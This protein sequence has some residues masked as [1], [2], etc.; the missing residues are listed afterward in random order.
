MSRDD[1]L[2]ALGRLVV[3][4]RTL[5][6]LREARERAEA[7]GH[8]EFGGPEIDRRTLEFR[9]IAKE[10][11]GSLRELDGS[12]ARRL[13]AKESAVREVVE[14]SRSTSGSPAPA[15]WM[16]VVLDYHRLLRESLAIK[17]WLA[18]RVPR[19]E[20]VGAATVEEYLEDRRARRLEPMS[21]LDAAAWL[22]SHRRPPGG[23]LHNLVFRALEEA[24]GLTRHAIERAI[25]GPIAGNAEER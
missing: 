15:A 25:F 22:E 21:L 19:G 6:E 17:A 12:G 10:F 4:Y 16:S 11:P 24:H 7:D 8:R 20:S 18:S 13:R 2:A 23:R 1:L 5:A 3:K 14:R 9:R